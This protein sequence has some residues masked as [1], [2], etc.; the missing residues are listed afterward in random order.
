MVVALLLRE[1]LIG[2]KIYTDNYKGD[3][4]NTPVF[5]GTSDPDPH[6]PVQRVHDT[7]KILRGMNAS[8]TEKIY[9]RIGHTIIQDEFDHANELLRS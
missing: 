3:F 5:I 1:D 2:D 8:V 4:Q 7:V 6:V 9:E